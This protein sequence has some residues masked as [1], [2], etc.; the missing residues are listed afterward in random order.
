MS[1]I[2]KNAFDDI[3]PKAEKGNKIIEII[4]S[5]RPSLEGYII[6]EDNFLGEYD[7]QLK[8]R[9]GDI[10][11]VLDFT[12]IEKNVLINPGVMP[13]FNGWRMRK[14]NCFKLDKE[15]SN[16]DILFN[17]TKNISGYV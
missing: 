3:E 9:D 17:N 15:V 2:I 14:R 8:N 13:Y 1:V 4:D 7:T 16:G 10:F 5:K 12:T 11:N 6:F